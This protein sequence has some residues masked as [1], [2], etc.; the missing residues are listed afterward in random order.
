MAAA[1]HGRVWL[2]GGGRA[3]QTFVYGEDVGRACL[4]ASDRGRPG[5]RY[6]IG[7]FGSTW[8]DPFSSAARAGGF[9]AGGSAPPHAIALLRGLPA[10]NGTPAGGAPRPRH[11]APLL[12]GH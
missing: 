12:P 11:H 3:K 4:A 1:V 9:P 10:P 6:L 8:R 7:G 5:H 2:P